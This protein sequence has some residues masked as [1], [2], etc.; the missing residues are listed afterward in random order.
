MRLALSTNMKFYNSMAK[1]LKLGA[2]RFWGLRSMFAEI[3]GENLVWRAFLP[4][5]WAILSRIKVDN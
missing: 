3:T 1:E 2:K 5:P 4:T